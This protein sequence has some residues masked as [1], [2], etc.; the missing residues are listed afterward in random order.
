VLGPFCRRCSFVQHPDRQRKNA[1]NASNADLLTKLVGTRYGL[2][3]EE[4]TLQRESQKD[5]LGPIYPRV[6]C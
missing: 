2:Q 3:G 6:F 5:E 4:L 1:K